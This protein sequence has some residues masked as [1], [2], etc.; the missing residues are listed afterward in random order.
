MTNL[1]T[2][3]GYQVLASAG[4]TVLRPGGRIATEQL[5]AWANFQPGE[6][7]FGIGIRIRY[8]RDRFG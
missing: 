3:P 8:Q 7:C 4:K 6:N 5:F 1:Q 2:A